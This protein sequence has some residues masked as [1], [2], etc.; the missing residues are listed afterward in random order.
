ML[1]NRS[2]ILRVF[3]SICFF[4]LVVSTEAGSAQSAPA[5]VGGSRIAYPTY[6]TP[7]T[8]YSS[9]PASCDVGFVTDVGGIN[10]AGFNQLTYAGLMRAQL[11][12]GV[13]V[14][15]MRKPK[16]TGLCG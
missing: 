9:Y 6:R 8:S 16:A 12:F 3:L 14:R 15:W 7:S 2:P 1:D 11:D 5:S 10:D 4:V 13:D